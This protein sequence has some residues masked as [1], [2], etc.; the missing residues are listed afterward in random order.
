MSA[1]LSLKLAVLCAS[2]FAVSCSRSGGDALIVG[3]SQGYDEPDINYFFSHPRQLSEVIGRYGFPARTNAAEEKLI[4]YDY[5]IDEASMPR[6]R[7]NYVEG[8]SVVVSNGFVIKHGFTVSV[9]Y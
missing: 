5:C 3:K 4:I 7:S 6:Y 1:L 8:F 9:M 2:C